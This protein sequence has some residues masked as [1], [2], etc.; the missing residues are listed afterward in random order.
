MRVQCVLCDAIHELDDDSPLAKR[1][2]NRPIHT[3]MCPD[4]HDRITKKTL[5][6]LATG[7]FRF[8]RSSSSIDKEL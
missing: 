8:Y 2:R 6:R 7:K 5:E 4:C 1:L 3:F